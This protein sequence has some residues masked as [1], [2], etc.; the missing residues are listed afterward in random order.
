MKRP[1]RALFHPDSE[2]ARGAR[3]EFRPRITR[4]SQT[5]SFTKPRS[6]SWSSSFSLS[7]PIRRIGD[8]LKLELRHHHLPQK[9]YL[10]H[11]KSKI[12]TH[13]SSIPPKSQSHISTTYHFPLGASHSFHKSRPA[14][15]VNLTTAGG[16]L[17]LVSFTSRVGKPR[18]S[19]PRCLPCRRCSVRGRHTSSRA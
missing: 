17:P 14:R 6:D 4:I 16:Y 18:R 5:E 12:L 10:P 13:P 7:S 2:V 1:M 19:S 15:V 8:K 11:Q 3:R 9:T